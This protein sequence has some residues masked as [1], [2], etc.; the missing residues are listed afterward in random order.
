[1]CTVFTKCKDNLENGRRLENLS[2]R[3]WY[4][5]TRVSTEPIHIPQLQQQQQ[6]NNSGSENDSSYDASSVE[7]SLVQTPPAFKHVSPSSFKRMITSFAEP[8]PAPTLVMHS[9]AP[10]VMDKPL[11]Q[12]KFFVSDD[13]ED[14][15]DDEQREDYDTGNEY[16]FEL[17]NDNN[18]DQEEDDEE[19]DGCWSTVRSDSHFEEAYKA[20]FCKRTPAAPNR[21]SLLSNML[22]TTTAAT[23]T[24]V[25]VSTAAAAAHVRPVPI[26]RAPRRFR[27][28]R[29]VQQTH[30]VEPTSEL[31]QSLKYCV[32]WE[33]RQ[34]A[35]PIERPSHRSPLGLVPVSSFSSNGWFLESFRGW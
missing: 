5:E 26:N 31:S 19:D 17:D 6:E 9:P 33:H 2:W 15:D 23:T 24:N 1:M 35:V 12:S 13:E 21:R 25:V 29:S 10:S 18:N 34:N 4:R 30:L 16:D 20:E 32:E 8:S 27:K 7:S 28:Q 3:L 22:Q 11:M 14:D